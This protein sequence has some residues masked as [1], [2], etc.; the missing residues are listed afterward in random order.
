MNYHL[1]PK[2]YIFYLLITIYYE[3]TEFLIMIRKKTILEKL[4]ICL[5]VFVYSRKED[6]MR[7]I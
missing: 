1:Y 4:F 3:I 2:M 7:Y 6:I 5:Y